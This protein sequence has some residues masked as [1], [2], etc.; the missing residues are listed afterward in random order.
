M[1]NTN[2]P[3]PIT[4]KHL[5]TGFLIRTRCRGA[6]ST[7]GSRVVATIDNGPS[8]PF[9]ASVSWEYGV[10]PQDNHYLAALAVLRKLSDATGLRL[11][12]QAVANDSKGCCF[13]TT[14]PQ[15]HTQPS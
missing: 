13:I 10:S 5:P 12:I 11:S 15:P 6:T 14:K 2:T 9:R 3:T 7:K 1:E 4:A 8:R